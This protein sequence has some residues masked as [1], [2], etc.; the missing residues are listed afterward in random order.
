MINFFK[1]LFAQSYVKKI[2]KRS[3]DYEQNII[4]SSPYKPGVDFTI[5]N[6]L[7]TSI[8]SVQWTSAFL[9]LSI[10]GIL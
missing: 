10:I 6:Q 1:Y 4:F 2:L 7:L 3:L 8:L 5:D 9:K